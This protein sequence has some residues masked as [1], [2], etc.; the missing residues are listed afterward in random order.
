MLRSKVSD[1]N[2]K[3]HCAA[4]VGNALVG[5][6]EARETDELPLAGDYI[7]LGGPDA[8]PLETEG[9]FERP[10]SSAGD[11]SLLGD[12]FLKPDATHINTLKR[13]FHIRHT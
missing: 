11:Y 6:E 2:N 1:T 13:A 8:V 9:P 12:L 3:K 5:E 4:E 10:S 7:G